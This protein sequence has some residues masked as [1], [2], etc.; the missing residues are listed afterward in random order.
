ML[1]FRRMM[2][3]CDLADLGSVAAVAEQR[4]ITSSAVSQ[5]LRV[6]EQEAGTVLF[7]RD[8]RTLGLTRAGDVLVEHVRKVVTALDEATSAVAAFRSDIVGNVA[9]ASF[10]MGIAMLAAPVMSRLRLRQP[11]LHIEIQQER[12]ATALRLLRRRELDVAIL[13]RYRFDAPLS[14]GGLIE[15]TLM[16]EP[17]TLLAPPDQHGRIRTRGLPA[18]ADSPWVAGPTNSGLGAVLQHAAEAAGFTPKVKHR[19][20]GAQNLCML[21]ATEAASA[22]VP[23]MAVPGHLEGLIVDGVQLGSRTISAVVRQGRERD[24]NIRLVVD[25]LHS[26]AADTDHTRTPLGVAV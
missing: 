22:I 4:G 3:L 18:L 23:R 8:G 11:N 26:V 13:C 17:M 21:A 15:E 14:L 16:D 25:E 5:Q 12:A 6:L 9:V 7:R 1:D 19:V 20:N 2:L 24:P 10:N